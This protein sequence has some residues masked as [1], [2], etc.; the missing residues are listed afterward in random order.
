[1]AY[2]RTKNVMEGYQSLAIEAKKGLVKENLD[3]LIK[4]T[5]TFQKSVFDQIKRFF[6]SLQIMLDLLFLNEDA[7]KVK[8]FETISADITNAINDGDP[9][10][11]IRDLYFLETYLVDESDRQKYQNVLLKTSLAYYN[12]NSVNDLIKLLYEKGSCRDVDETPI[13]PTPAP[14]IHYTHQMRES[15]ETPLSED[16]FGPRSWGPFFWNIFH[17]L[18]H[19]AHRLRNKYDEEELCQFLYGYI[20]YLPLLIPCW[21]CTSHFY[22]TINPGMIQ[23][24]SNVDDYKCIYD[25]I[26]NAVAGQIKSRGI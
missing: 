4:D 2:H 26:H 24:S 9:G 20:Q 6:S 22:E 7:V 16:I 18:P 13:P 5:V 12:V 3:D 14:S 23:Y 19:N 15:N 11:K 10:N 17:S 8:P 1:M 25:N 21:I